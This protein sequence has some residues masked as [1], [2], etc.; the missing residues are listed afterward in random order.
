[1]LLYTSKRCPVSGF[2]YLLANVFCK[3]TQQDFSKNGLYITFGSQS[4]TFKLQV[5][6]HFF[7][8]AKRDKIIFIC[9]TQIEIC[10]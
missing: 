4:L 5:I 1:M 8:K 9:I 10:A 7:L 3:P 2:H 6:W